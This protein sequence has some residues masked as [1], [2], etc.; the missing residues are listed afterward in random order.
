MEEDIFY[1]L[2]YIWFGFMLNLCATG[3]LRI[4][5]I[6]DWMGA[7]VPRGLQIRL[8]VTNN[9]RGEFD[10]HPFPQKGAGWLKSGA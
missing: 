2:Y 5:V 10:S 9:S 6:R 1:M 3:L 7:G 8:S 4:Q